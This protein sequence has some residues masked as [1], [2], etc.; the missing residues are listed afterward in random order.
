MPWLNMPVRASRRVDSTSWRCWRLRRACAARNTRKSRPA[1]RT[2]AA[3]VTSMTSR[4]L[5]SRLAMRSLAFRHKATTASGRPCPSM[6]GRNSSTVPSRFSR[7]PAAWSGRPA[8]M[9]SL[10]PGDRRRPPDAA[11][12]TPVSAPANDGSLPTMT[13]PDRS[14]ISIR[15]IPSRSLSAA[16]SVVSCAR[17]AAVGPSSSTSPASSVPFTNSSISDASRFTTPPSVAFAR[18]FEVTATSALAVTPTSTR[19][20]PNTSARSIGR[21]RSPPV[22]R[23]SNMSPDDTEAPSTGR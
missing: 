4:R 2:A 13:R 12:V 11:A 3:S 1:S 20:T 17:R 5:A 19:T 14:R 21:R 18:W 16:S 22:S 8:S 10:P 15:T 6:I 23:A 7:A 9:R